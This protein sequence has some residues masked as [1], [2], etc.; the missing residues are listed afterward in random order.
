MTITLEEQTMSDEVLH[1]TLVEIERILND[2]PLVRQTD[3][4]EDQY[5]LTPNKLLML[6]G[7]VSTFVDSIDSSNRFTRRWR[8]MQ[9]LANVFWKKWINVYLPTLQSLQRWHTAKPNL[10]AGELVLMVERN[11]P[12]GQWPKAIIESV[13]QG[14]DGLVRDVTVRTATGSM[15]RDIRQLCRLEGDVIPPDATIS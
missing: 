15:R 6:R 4:P 8:A 13:H 12:R 5:V 9:H 3:D 14:T 11:V 7:E 2:R 1:T 10:K